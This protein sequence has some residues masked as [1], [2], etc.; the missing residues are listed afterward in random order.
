MSPERDEQEQMCLHRAAK[1]HR[2]AEAAAS[3]HVREEY[4]DLERR[5]LRLAESYRFVRSLDASRG[6]KPEP[7]KLR[8]H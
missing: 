4:L 3:V 7:R 1:W 6:Q 2:M 8:R 5:W